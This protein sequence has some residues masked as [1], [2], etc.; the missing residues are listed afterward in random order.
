MESEKREVIEV[1]ERKTQEILRQ[2]EEYQNLTERYDKLRKEIN[3]IENENHELKDKE[4]SWKVCLVNY[5][6]K[7]N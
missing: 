4:I 7:E 6:R 3:S 5:S 2:E 1:I